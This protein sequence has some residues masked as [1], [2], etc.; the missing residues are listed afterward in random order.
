MVTVA[1]ILSRRASKEPT[2]K[3]PTISDIVRPT[4]PEELRQFPIQSATEA[5]GSA[6]GSR[7]L[8]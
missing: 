3:P 6:L 2:G 7:P 5:L 4:L 1:E 8:G